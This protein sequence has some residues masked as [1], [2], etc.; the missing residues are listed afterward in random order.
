[1]SDSFSIIHCYSVISMSQTLTRQQI[2]GTFKDE[3]GLIPQE[4]FS[5]VPRSS[6]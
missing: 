5:L 4:A 6:V 3:Q 2:N 1:M